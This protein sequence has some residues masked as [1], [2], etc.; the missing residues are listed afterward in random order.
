MRRHSAAGV[1]S[2]GPAC[3]GHS[4]EVG[5][6]SLRGCE[7]A[8]RAQVSVLGN[9]EHC[10][11]SYENSRPG[12]KRMRGEK[13][14]DLSAA[15]QHI[16]RDDHAGFVTNAKKSRPLGTFLRRRHHVPQQQAAAVEL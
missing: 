5:Q 14:D 15:G 3:D 4:L 12:K 7:S 1:G 13:G 16:M 2:M 11:F 9:G 6:T 8:W 10:P